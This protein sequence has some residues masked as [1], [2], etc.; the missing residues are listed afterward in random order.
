MALLL[1]LLLLLLL[2]DDDGVVSISI[3]EDAGSAIVFEIATYDVLL[4]SESMS[5]VSINAGAQWGFVAPV[6]FDKLL[7]V[8]LEADVGVYSES[9]EGRG[10]DLERY[11]T[12]PEISPPISKA[13]MVLLS[14]MDAELVVY[15]ARLCHTPL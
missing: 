2:F 11:S 6:L 14:C 1:L 12:I 10:T 5:S 13:N 3:P 7:G 4:N 8:C 15:T 9:A